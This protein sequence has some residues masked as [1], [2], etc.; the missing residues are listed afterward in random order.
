M[1]VIDVE[2]TGTDW[3]YHSILSI[4]A[5]D[6]DDPENEFYGECRAFKGAKIEPE[7]LAINRF[8]ESDAKDAT[9]MSDK[10]LLLKFLAWVQGVGD[11]TIA[12]ENPSF[13]RDFLRAAAER[14]GIDWT[15]AYRTIDLHSVAYAH[16]LANGV[17]PPSKNGHTG[18]NLPKIA[19]Y[20]G[21]PENPKAHDAHDDALYTA[22][23]LSRLVYGQNLVEALNPYP[24][25]HHLS[26]P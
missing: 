20:C 8:T 18:L 9:K 26:R 13:D 25:P 7:A 1:I 23:C 3:R 17:E 22:E 14:Y 16:M 2:T 6:F 10:D 15:F 5:I 12:G 21:L 24:I 11:K 19:A 4:G